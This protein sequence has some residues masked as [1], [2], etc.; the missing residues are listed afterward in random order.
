MDIKDYKISKE[1]YEDIFKKSNVSFKS[2]YEYVVPY[3]DAQ[4]ADMKEQGWVSPEDISQVKIPEGLRKSISDELCYICVHQFTAP[5]VVRGICEKKSCVLRRKATDNIL[6]KFKLSLARYSATDEEMVEQ[7][8]ITR[9]QDL[10]NAKKEE[11]ERVENIAF[12][13]ISDEEELQG[14]M[15]NTLWEKIRNDRDLVT[16]VTQNAVRL[17]KESITERLK[18]TLKE[19][20]NV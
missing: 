8:A 2:Y 11:R 6:E 9:E 1:K 10:L 3:L 17:T 12:K 15:P 16:R 18:S 4:I 13:A 5:N 7:L 20:S 19:G 14:D